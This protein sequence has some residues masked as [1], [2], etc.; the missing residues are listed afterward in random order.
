[1]RKFVLGIVSLL[2]MLLLCSCT[3]LNKTP[4]EEQILS[5]YLAKNIE[6]EYANFNAIEIKR[7]QLNKGDKT[8]VAD[9]TLIGKDEYAD[10]ICS[11]SVLYNYY[12]DQG[13]MLD[14]ITNSELTTT[15]HTGRTLEELEKDIRINYTT[16]LPGGLRV[17]GFNV[18][19]ILD[20]NTQLV[21]FTCA[22][23]NGHLITEYDVSMYFRYGNGNWF[24]DNIVKN[25]FNFR[26][27]LQGTIWENSTQF[28]HDTKISIKIKKISEDS[29]TIVLEYGGNDYTGIL[30][31]DYTEENFNSEVS[32][33][34]EKSIALSSKDYAIWDTRYTHFLEDFKIKFGSDYSSIVIHEAMYQ[35]NK[36]WFGDN[37]Y[38]GL[39]NEVPVVVP[40]VYSY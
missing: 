25:P 12:D 3:G 8:F 36:S 17:D 23:A 13:W 38:L 18:E 22:I 27:N 28:K 16:Y 34:L 24:I 1:M 30:E 4:D 20:Q 39:K 15:C 7:S 19:D 5:D 9:I 26:V 37:H 33:K 14:K 11:S 40:E 21:T 10:Y 6:T 29:R 35:N 32:Y 31:S 2:I